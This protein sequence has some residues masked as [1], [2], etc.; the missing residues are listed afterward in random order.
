MTRF[1][2]I[3][4]RRMAE[5][6]RSENTDAETLEFFDLVEKFSRRADS[7]YV[8]WSAVAREK[9]EKRIAELFE[10]LFP[11]YSGEQK[12]EIFKTLIE[13]RIRRR[14]VYTHRLSMLS[15]ADEPCTTP[16]DSGEPEEVTYTILKRDTVDDR[17]AN[18]LY[19]EYYQKQD[20]LT[21][22]LSEPLDEFPAFSYWLAMKT[23]IY[24]LEHVPAFSQLVKSFYPKTNVKQLE[25]FRKYAQINHL[26]EQRD[27]YTFLS[28]VV[29]EF[30]E[31][32]DVC[33]GMLQ[34]YADAVRTE[35]SVLTKADREQIGLL[36]DMPNRIED[37]RKQDLWQ[38]RQRI[39]NA[40]LSTGDFKRVAKAFERSAASVHQ[41]LIDL[42]VM[43]Q[44]GMQVQ[45]S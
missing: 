36:P 24:G 39:R 40:Y 18:I 17:K 9:R 35:A 22:Q 20:T 21:K 25:Q 3:A 6:E 38:L 32:V 13:S 45:T 7:P 43:E 12:D 26:R 2:E 15:E 14:H 28:K 33:G 29:G 16:F 11:A 34:T 5:R 37:L 10:R 23:L 42:G 19:H 27:P 30:P 41:L 4:K 8:I 31:L 1:G 44:R